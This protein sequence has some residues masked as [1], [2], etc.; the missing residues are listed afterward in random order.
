MLGTCLNAAFSS[1]KWDAALS[2]MTRFIDLETSA[3]VY[4]WVIEREKLT[5]RP[6]IVLRAPMMVTG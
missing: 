1:S 3:C 6:W 2:F 5:R 4:I